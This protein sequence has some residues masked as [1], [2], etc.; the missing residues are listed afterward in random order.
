MTMT[1]RA[2]IAGLA[3]LMALLAVAAGY[4]VNG[5][6][7]AFYVSLITFLLTASSCLFDRCTQSQQ[8]KTIRRTPR[9]SR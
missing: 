9:G 1:Y 8:E 5:W 3:L 2:R 6:R 7:G 4:A